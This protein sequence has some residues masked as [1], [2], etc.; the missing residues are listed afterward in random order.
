MSDPTSIAQAYLDTW[1]ATGEAQRR[2]ML[3][4]HWTADASYVD[5]LMRGEG[6]EQIG[7]LVDA[8]QQRY[9]GFRF[10]LV[11]TPNGHGN[12]VRLSWALG[13]G[14]GEAPIEGS[15]VVCLSEGRIRRVIGFI[16]RAPSA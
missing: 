16:D 10:S 5:P 4:Q 12:F 8:V 13:P 11:G 15:D 1:N 7:G 6:T 3:A 2:A 9:P 14:A